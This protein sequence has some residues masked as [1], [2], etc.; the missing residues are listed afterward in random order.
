MTSRII[1]SFLSQR[2]TILGQA[3]HSFYLYAK[4][5]TMLDGAKKDLK[6]EEKVPP[7]SWVEDIFGVSFSYPRTLRVGKGGVR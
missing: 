1:S 7:L 4:S 5:L 2:R 3:F 6:K